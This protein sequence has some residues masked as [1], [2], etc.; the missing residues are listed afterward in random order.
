MSSKQVTKSKSAFDQ[1]KVNGTWFKGWPSDWIL[2]SSKQLGN[3]TAAAHDDDDAD[4]T[5]TAS[6]SLHVILIFK[7]LES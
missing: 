3:T 7:R 6:G 5:I 1:G 4:G 2:L